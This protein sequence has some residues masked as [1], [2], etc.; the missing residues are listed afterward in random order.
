MNYCLD[1]PFHS[2]CE[3]TSIQLCK[4]EDFE[5][6]KLINGKYTIVRIFF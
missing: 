6:V 4:L 3:V 1:C 5:R 2:R